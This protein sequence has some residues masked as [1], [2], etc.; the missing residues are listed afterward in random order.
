MMVS[1]LTSFQIGGQGGGYRLHQEDTPRVEKLLKKVI[2]GQVSI[3][4]Y[5][6]RHTGPHPTTKSHRLS[7]PPRV[8]LDNAISPSATVI[9]VQADDRVGLGYQIA[10]TLASLHLNITFAKLATEKAHAFDVF[11][12]QN[13]DGCKVVDSER[14]KKLLS[15]CGQM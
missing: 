12:V 6:K 2:A 13:Q 8:R 1:S 9:E 14:M 11:Y 15:S 4:D 5:L 10:K 3:E 7:F